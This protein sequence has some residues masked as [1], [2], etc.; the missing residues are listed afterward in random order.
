MKKDFL[1]IQSTLVENYLNGS[2]KNSKICT[3]KK[4]AKQLE[5][6]YKIKMKKVE[7][8]NKGLGLCM[9]EIIKK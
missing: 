3:T 8:V 9:F 7:V 5:E 6:K 2:R 1:V 4:V